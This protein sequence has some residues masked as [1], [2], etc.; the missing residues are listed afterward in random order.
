MRRPVSNWKHA[1]AVGRATASYEDAGRRSLQR[2]RS[3]P[4]EAGFRGDA[5]EVRTTECVEAGE[6]VA[7]SGEAAFARATDHGKAQV[8]VPGVRAKGIAEFAEYGLGEGI[9]LGR[10][11]DEH[12]ED[13]IGG[14]GLDG[15]G[16][17]GGSPR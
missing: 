14:P 4:G 7:A 2:R 11:V 8:G 17:N 10:A 1:F 12:V 15:G 3:Y 16:G 5:P 13:P 9:A 6:Q